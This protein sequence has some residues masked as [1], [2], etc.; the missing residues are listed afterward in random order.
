LDENFL[1]RTKFS[2]YFPTAKN[3]GVGEAIGTGCKR[4]KH[5]P[6]QNF[7]D[8]AKVKFYAGCKSLITA[9]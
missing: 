9:S 7:V 1:T 5:S 6:K 3:L 8:I 4:A 2:D